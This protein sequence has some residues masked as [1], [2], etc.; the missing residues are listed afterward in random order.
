MFKCIEGFFTIP[1][2]ELSDQNNKV[3]YGYFYNPLLTDERQFFYADIA[4]HP[5]VEALFGVKQLRQELDV[6]IKKCVELDN[7]N[8]VSQQHYKEL[9]DDYLNNIYNFTMFKQSVGC[10]TIWQRLIFLFTRKLPKGVNNV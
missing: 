9:T 2:K 7:L 6:K 8:K 5:D 4:V 10:M 3:M 1:V